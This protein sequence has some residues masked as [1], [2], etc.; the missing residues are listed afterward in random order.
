MKFY[1]TKNKNVAYSLREAV[2]KGLPDDN[3]LFVPAY[4]PGLSP[5][6]FSELSRKS[7]ATIAKEVAAAF[8]KD[9][10]QE[11]D[12]ESIVSAAINFDAPLVR[13]FPSLNILELFHGPTLAFKDF[14]ARFMAR[15]IS[16]LLRG[17][18]NKVT[19][20]VATSGDT[21]SAVANGFYEVDGINVIILYPSGK[22]S[23]LQEL[24]LTTLGKNITAIEVNGTFDDCQ[25]LVKTAFLDPQLKNSNLSSANSI[26]ISRLIPQSFYYFF[27]AAQADKKEIVFSVPSGNFG[28]LTA[29][30]IANKMGL[31]VKAFVAATNSNK[32]VPEYLQTGIF[33]PK[34]SVSTIS[35]AMDVGNPSNFARM[36]DLCHH[37]VEEMRKLIFGYSFSDEET[38]NAMKNVFRE[39]DYIIDPHGAI[40]VLGLQ[41]YLLAHRD[42]VTGIVLETAHPAKFIDVVE[43]VLSRKIDLPPALAEVA[44]RKKIAVAMENDYQ[45]L[46]D[47]LLAG[48]K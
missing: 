30:L 45:S 7:L 47:F 18:D 20:L 5:E 1:S 27:A 14:G 25:H 23:K 24:Q 8:L 48:E 38:K 35:N 22:V 33:T 29:G 16:F 26:N 4:I 15:L 44:S 46:K 42:P 37:S 10:I 13:L 2:L 43:E 31:P 40:G 34:P 19:I 6:F 36:S 9:D 28:N 41:K 12:L 3:G 39:Y 21:G 32:T 17:S 11:K